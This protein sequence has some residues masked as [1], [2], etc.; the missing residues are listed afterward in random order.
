[1]DVYTVIF[2]MVIMVICVHLTL[3]YAFMMII[4]IIIIVM[5]IINMHPSILQST[6]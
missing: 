6:H 2:G 5:I 3:V 1:M 4:I